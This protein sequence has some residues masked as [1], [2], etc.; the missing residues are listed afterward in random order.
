MG[1]LLEPF[2]GRAASEVLWNW[3]AGASWAAL[4][5]IHRSGRAALILDAQYV[6]RMCSGLFLGGAWLQQYAQHMQPEP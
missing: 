6:L 5:K 4:E 2:R 1:V 3:R